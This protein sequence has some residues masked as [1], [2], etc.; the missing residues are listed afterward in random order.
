MQHKYIQQESCPYCGGGIECDFSG[1]Y[2]C[3]FVGDEIRVFE[4][5]LVLVHKTEPDAI[6]C[7]EPC[8]HSEENRKKLK[9]IDEAAQ[10]IY[11]F[12]DTL[13]IDDVLKNDIKA[14]VAIKTIR[15]RK[16]VQYY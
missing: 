16:R 9:D 8:Y 14:H 5:G 11:D 7:E 2:A 15:T 3:N 12:V 13:N 4:C 10:A 1:R 6:C